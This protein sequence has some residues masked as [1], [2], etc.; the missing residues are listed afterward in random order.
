MPTSP[1][2]VQPDI[3]LSISLPDPDVTPPPETANYFHFAFAGADVQMLVGYVDLRQ[4]HEATT[5][6]KARTL[7]PAISHRFLLSPAGFTILRS[8]VEEI[9]KKYDAVHSAGT[10]K[11]GPSGKD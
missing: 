10:T 4:L 1:M 11:V 9:S 8:M 5:N 6:P 2:P 7:T 3:Q